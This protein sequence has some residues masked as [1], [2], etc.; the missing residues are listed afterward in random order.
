MSLLIL[1]KFFSALFDTSP[2]L[3]RSKFLFRDYP[4]KKKIM[5]STIYLVM[6]LGFLMFFK[7]LGIDGGR[8]WGVPEVLKHFLPSPN[9]KKF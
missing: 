3:N 6:H 9:F 1:M 7:A 8:G 5:Y 2:G 4:K